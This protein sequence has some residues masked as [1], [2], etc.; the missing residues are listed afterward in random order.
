[1]PPLPSPAFRD[2]LTALTSHVERH[3]SRTA[4]NL[5]RMRAVRA[6]LDEPIGSPPSPA[7]TEVRGRHSIQP[8]TQDSSDGDD[9]TLRA[10]VPRRANGNGGQ[11]GASILE[12]VARNYGVDR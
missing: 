5:A 10:R 4:S 12:R 2:A 7:P 3:S 8:P 6:T 11:Y 1:V 9:A